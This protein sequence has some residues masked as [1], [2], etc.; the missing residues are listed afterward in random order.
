MKKYISLTA[1]FLVALATIIVVSC[2]KDDNKR[3]LDT[4]NKEVARFEPSTVEDID[5]YLADFKQRLGS[6]KGEGTMCIED[7][8]WH[9]GAL[10]NYD[11]GYFNAPHNAILTETLG[12][13][14]N[15]DNGEVKLSD[16]AVAY[17]DIHETIENYFQKLDLSNKQIHFVLVDAAENGDLSIKVSVTYDDRYH[18]WYPDDT[19]YCQAYIYNQGPFLNFGNG[20]QLLED[21]LNLIESYNMDP[22]VGQTY[23][24]YSGE[25]YPMPNNFID[26][27]GSPNFMD[28]RIYCTNAFHYANIP[29]DCMC[30]YLQ[31]YHELGLSYL[32]NST[33]LGDVIAMWN[34]GEDNFGPNSNLSSPESINEQLTY[35]HKLKITFG[36]VTTHGGGGPYD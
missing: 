16:L 28:S 32:Y 19:T 30:Y 35:Y 2:K 29:E 1:L 7:A 34:I 13:H 14:V 10:A 27:Y 11:F 21:L 23:A 15:V 36:Y 8:A 6:E 20:R 31:S 22:N 18:N 3:V 12:G 17:D 25:R 26:P 5:A 4:Q 9:L 24:L 33:T